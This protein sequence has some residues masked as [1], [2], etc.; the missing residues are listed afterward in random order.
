MVKRV[1]EILVNSYVGA[2]VVALLF[3][4]AV[5]HFANMLATAT[6][7]WLIE[8]PYR[9]ST[10]PP[11]FRVQSISPELVRGIFILLIC[12]LLLYWLYF[13]RRERHTEQTE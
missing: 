5:G 10:T 13:P 2:I 6:T 3:A 4:Q 12:G 11:G 9:A 1:Q 8:G 7:N